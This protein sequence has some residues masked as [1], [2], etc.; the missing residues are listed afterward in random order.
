MGSGKTYDAVREK[1][2]TGVAQGRRVVTNIEGI[3]P[4]RIYDYVERKLNIPPSSIGEVV[5]VDIERPG[6]PGFF[7]CKVHPH[8]HP[9]DA[10]RVDD[11]ESVV[12]GGDLV[13]IDEARRFWQAGTKISEEHQI[14]FA[15]HRHYTGKNNVSCDMVYIIQDMS[16]VHRSLKAL[17]E[18]TFRFKKL[19]TLGLARFYVVNQWEGY[20]LKKELIVNTFNKRYDAEIYPLYKSYSG[21]EPGKELAVDKRQ[22]VFAQPKL[23]LLVGGSAVMFCISLKFIYSVFY[24]SAAKASVPDRPEAVVRSA[25]AMPGS[26]N[27]PKAAAAPAPTPKPSETWRISGTLEGRDGRFVVLVSKDGKT[28]LVQPDASW[29]YLGGRYVSGT[30]DGEMVGTFTGIS[31]ERAASSPPRNLTP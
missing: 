28:R 27:N 9:T 19:K 11:T 2:V 3:N 29:I 30:V 26:P 7:P 21:A 14:F 4:E 24:P 16:Q 5:S 22:N 15:E 12:K 1:V 10:G 31:T 13:V 8:D 17:T 20:N 23:W 25:A 6:K 18:L